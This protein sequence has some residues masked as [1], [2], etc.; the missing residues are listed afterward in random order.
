MHFPSCSYFLDFANS[1]KVMVVSFVNRVSVIVYHGKNLLVKY[2]CS[3]SAEVEAA[4]PKNVQQSK[5]TIGSE[6]K[7]TKGPLP[8]GFFD[9][10]N[11][12]SSSTKTTSEPKQSQTQTTGG[13]ES[14]PVVKG[15]LPTGFFD[16]KEA[17]LLARGIK[18]VKPDI[19]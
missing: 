11:T 4:K 1:T 17:D 19:K 5:Q 10:Q 16:N 18:I 12:D 6:T 3:E 14:K 15:A 13:S 9:N 8:D 2:M 7:K